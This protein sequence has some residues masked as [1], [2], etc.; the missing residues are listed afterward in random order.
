MFRLLFLF[1]LLCHYS[2]GQ[3]TK[4]A[5]LWEIKSKDGKTTSYL[6]GTMHVMDAELFY[7]P[8]K[9]EKLLLKTDVLCMEISSI[10]EPD[11][12]PDELFLTNET[13]ADYFS[14]A[15]MDSIYRWA[16]K[17]LLMSKVQ[18]DTNFGKAKPFLL[19]QF[20][21]QSSLPE[22]TKSYEKEF[23]NIA[24]KNKKSQLGLESV[25]EQLNLFSGLSKK[26]Q[27]EMVM[28]SLRDEAKAKSSFQEMQKIYLTQNLDDLFSFMKKESDSPINSSRA[29]L[30]DRNQKWIPQMEKMIEAK[31]TF[32]AVGA[33]HL[34]GPE[35]VIELL[36]KKGYSLTPIKL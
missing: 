33:A 17:S 27:T 25:T 28:S 7:F 21:L 34:A 29:F 16:E 13:L 31:S 19:V 22:N 20:L 5:L 30:E 32:F 23:E 26:E 2:I 9:L 10:I 15:Q 1:V 6:Y 14:S 24:T 11:I 12:S 36:I 4:D 8:K 18:F 3:V 35:G